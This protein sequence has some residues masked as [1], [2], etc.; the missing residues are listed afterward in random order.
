M[1]LLLIDNRVRSIEYITNSLEEGV[2]FFIFDYET[3]TLEGLKSKITKAYDCIGIVQDQDNIPS[4]TLAKPMGD[5]D[6]NDYSTWT[7]YKELVE[8]AS[9]LGT[10]IWD[11]IECNIDETWQPVITSLQS[12][13]GIT[14]RSSSKQLGNTNLGD[15][16]VFDDGTSLIGIYFTSAIND[17]PHILGGDFSVCIQTIIDINGVPWVQAN[18]GNTNTSSGFL[19][20]GNQTANISGNFLSIKTGVN[21]DLSNCIQTQQ[22]SNGGGQ[23]FLIKD[24]TCYSC[25]INSYYQLGHPTLNGIYSYATKITGISDVKAISTG[26]GFSMFLKNNGDLYVCG[27]SGYGATTLTSTVDA[28]S[29]KL[30]SALTNVFQVSCSR[31]TTLVV[32][33]DKMNIVYLYGADGRYNDQSSTSSTLGRSPNPTSLTTVGNRNIKQIECGAKSLYYIDVLNNLYATGFNNF[34]QLGTGNRTTITSWETVWG[35]PYGALTGVVSKISSATATLQ[36]LTLSGDLYMCGLL[37]WT[38]KSTD[39]A[40][41]SIDNVPTSD[42]YYRSDAVKYTIGTKVLDIYSIIINWTASLGNNYVSC[43]FVTERQYRVL[44]SSSVSKPLYQNGTTIPIIPLTNEIKPYSVSLIDSVGSIWVFGNNT[45]GTNVTVTNGYNKVTKAFGSPVIQVSDTFRGTVVLLQNGDVWSFGYN[46][47]GELGTTVSSATD[48]TEKVGSG[49]GVKLTFAGIGANII[50]FIASGLY[51]TVFVT[52]AGA[53][54]SCG[55]NNYG[56]LGQGNTTNLTTPTAISTLSNITTCYCG[57]YHTF[58]LDNTG[59]LY[60]C[61]YNY[62]TELG[63]NFVSPTTTQL[64]YSTPVQMTGTFTNVATG[65]NH[66]RT[67]VAGTIYSSGLNTNGQLGLNNTNVFSGFQI[68]TNNPTFAQLFAGENRSASLT[69]SGSLF[70]WGKGIATKPILTD[71]DV[72]MV[73]EV[74]DIGIIY[75]KNNKYYVAYSSDILAPYASVPIPGIIPYK[76]YIRPYTIYSNT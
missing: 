62:N 69:S 59:K 9:N 8:W 60:T 12:E 32:F 73:Y 42:S 70:T 63:T 58:F 56:Q 19:G 33:S 31:D 71:I 28:G 66:S 61:G 34:G 22:L 24:G 37:P 72:T 3:E 23:I 21:T 13:F 30:T 50:K 47:Y 4:Y 1:K 39:S 46:Q 18:P 43:V 68:L 55:L 11:L 17:Y 25:G 57:A 15:N 20:Q 7:T 52:S 35:Y 40:P 67:I 36:I 6:L 64:F 26:F 38:N 14:I 27:T 48:T 5:Y 41:D 29:I 10:K 44:T 49:A 65:D 51:H 76:P 45:Y 2:E 75:I 54:Y 16:W 53:V 74:T